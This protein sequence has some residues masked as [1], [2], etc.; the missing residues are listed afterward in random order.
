MEDATRRTNIPV[1]RTPKIVQW[2]IKNCTRDELSF[3]ATLAN[4]K[5]L[6]LLNSIFT[7]LTDANV[8]EVFYKEVASAD[9]LALIRAASRGEVSGLKAFVAACQ[10]AKE[11]IEKKEEKK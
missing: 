2:L 4:G 6:P 1:D 5:N 8:Y 9:E 10:L 11:E 7:R 3:M